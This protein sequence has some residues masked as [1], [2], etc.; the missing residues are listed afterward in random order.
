MVKGILRAIRFCAK[1]ELSFR[2]HEESGRLELNKP[3]SSEGL[4]R[5]TLRLLAERG[6]E[7]VKLVLDAPLNATYLSPEIQNEMIE[8]LATKILERIL[9]HARSAQCFT[10]IGDETGLHGTEFLTICLRYALENGDLKEEFIGLNKVTDTTAE[11]IAASLLDRLKELDIDPKKMVGQGYDGA[12]NMA[13]KITGVQTRIQEHYPMADYF[14]CVSHKLNLVLNDAAATVQMS[15][16]M[17]RV[18]KITVFFDGSRSAKRYDIL[19]EKIMECVPESKRKR[20]AMLAPTRWVQRHETLIAFKDLLPAI[21]KAL[22]HADRTERSTDASDMQAGLSSISSIFSIIMAENVAGHLKFLASILQ[23]KDIDLVSAYEEIDRL[24]NIVTQLLDS[25]DQFDEIFKEATN[26]CEQIGITEPTLRYENKKKLEIEVYCEQELFRPY[27]KAL[28]EGFSKRFGKRQQTA[29]TLQMLI[30]ARAKEL[31]LE[32]ISDAVAQY[33]VFL[34]DP[35]DL[36]FEIT[37][38]KSKWESREEAPTNV[39]Q[40]LADM[41]TRLAYPN[42]HALLVVLASLPVSTATAERSF[43]TLGRIFTDLRATMTPDRV[44]HLAICST[45]KKELDELDLDEV[46]HMFAK[47][48][49]R[50][51]EF[52]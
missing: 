17:D 27:L 36:K 14:H 46:V 8:C 15:R 2:G 33:S 11:N 37:R 1:S 52:L 12:A 16:T 49:T 9:T 39:T 44:S 40:A 35:S 51:A 29:F 21:L 30:P 31:T 45:Y 19:K 23:A 6:D 26:L 7:D 48:T 22:E 10:L 20:I 43:S 28:I 5:E 38:W 18:R 42:I 41:T 13:G 24:R 47:M 4:F 25:K 50:R 3:G 32:K 34:P